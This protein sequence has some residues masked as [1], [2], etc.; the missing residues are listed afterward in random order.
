MLW[1]APEVWELQPL[2][3]ETGQWLHPWE[4]QD[5]VDACQ[6][7]ASSTGVGWALAAHLI[8]GSRRGWPQSWPG[9]CLGAH[10]SL[11]R[12]D[13]AGTATCL[14]LGVP[15]PWVPLRLLPRSPRLG[16]LLA[17]AAQAPPAC[18]GVE[19]RSGFRFLDK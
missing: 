10:L 12:E 18:R 4:P 17:G 9:Q 13:P 3:F 6:G 14:A 15:G 5:K 7:S 11:R 1:D 19:P 2:H 16:L 8:P